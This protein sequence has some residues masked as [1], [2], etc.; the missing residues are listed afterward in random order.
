MQM[1]PCEALY[2]RP[3]RSSV[4]WTEVG[5]S[6]TTGPELI[7]VTSERVDLIRKHLLTAQSW[8]KSYADRR[9]RPLE[10]EAGDHVFL[11]RFAKRGKLSPR[12]IG[13]FKV[14]KRAGIFSYQ[15]ALPLSLSSVH[16]IFHVSILQKYT[17]DPTHVVDW[18]ELVVD[19]NGTFRE[20]PVR[21]MDS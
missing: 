1:A 14:L 10:F 2:G 17:P 9:Q 13:P 3:C 4:C 18:N 12:Y 6:S 8:Q 5:E 16:D 21:I 15:L 7:R 19:T 11:I 20:G